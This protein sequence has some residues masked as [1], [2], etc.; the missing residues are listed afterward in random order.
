MKRS[1]PP[2]AI[3]RHVGRPQGLALVPLPEARELGSVTIAVEGRR[4][5]GSYSALIGC[6]RPLFG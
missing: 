2:C 3:A 4:W 1:A 6:Q 5:F